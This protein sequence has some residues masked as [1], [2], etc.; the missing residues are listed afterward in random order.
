MKPGHMVSRY[1]SPTSSENVRAEIS[2]PRTRRY[3]LTLDRCATSRRFDAALRLP[4][5]GG[6]SVSIVTC[7][8]SR[9]IDELNAKIRFGHA[10]NLV[11]H[12][13]SL[14]VLVLFFVV[15]A[16]QDHLGQPVLKKDLRTSSSRSL[17][18]RS[19]MSSP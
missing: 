16:F 18:N 10:N 4:R 12:G 6:R 15:A 3:A 14:R 5:F 19:T 2:A 9:Q 11:G 13:G 7:R 1:T 8:Q 17:P